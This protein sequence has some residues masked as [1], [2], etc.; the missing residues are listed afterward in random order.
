MFDT[1]LAKNVM[2]VQIGLFVLVPAIWGTLFFIMPHAKESEYEK[3]PLCPAPAFSWD[4]LLDNYTDSLDLYFS[5]NF[6]FRED[7][8]KM[9]FQFNRWKGWH[10]DE[11]TFYATTSPVE[12]QLNTDSLMMDSMAR[13]EQIIEAEGKAESSHGVMIYKGM[14]IQI[15]GGSEKLSN[16]YVNMVNTYEERFRGKAKVHVMITPTHQEYYLPNEYRHSSER[17][18]INYI[19][20]NVT[21]N[22]TTSDVCGYLQAHRNEYIFFNTDHH[23]TGR[24]AYYAYVAFCKANKMEPVPIEKMEQHFIPGYLGSL[25][26]LTL[27]PTVKERID[28]VE[29][30]I[31]PT[32]NK[33][34][35]LSGAN[36]SRRSPT[37]LFVKF[38]KGGNSY[39]V[40][41]G[42]DLP[43][44]CVDT[45]VKNGRKAVLIKNSYGNAF[46]PYLISHFEQVYIVDYRYFKGN[47]VNLVNQFGITDVI[48]MSNSFS[49]N[50]STHT[51]YILNLLNGRGGTT[52]T[53]TPATG[54][55]PTN[56]PT[57][58]PNGN[59]PSNTPTTPN[60]QPNPT[61]PPSN[62][63]SN[64]SAPSNPPAPTS[65]TGQ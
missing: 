21:K 63:P 46:A 3:R 58:T 65:P 55:T 50:T 64:P 19:Y 20:E 22:V 47:L 42:G 11:M 33:M 56:T 57:N 32:Q 8:V 52:T 43:L 24:G 27:D 41:L 7:F 35:I 40:F 53:T 34:Y 31:P 10:S 49:S 23:W 62:P 37:P 48:I 16:Q 12:G 59:T 13:A 15:F 25:Y 5:D 6:P 61:N 1:T 51:S 14:A 45:D 30:L 18:I 9:A 28:S 38:A 4:A 39:G 60:K 36:Y 44:L 54:S 17:K 2:R 26:R 29:Y